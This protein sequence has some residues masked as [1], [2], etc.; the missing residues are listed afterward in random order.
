MKRFVCIV[1]LVISIISLY[2][3][4]GVDNQAYL[5]IHIRA[6]SNSEDDQN[7]KY[8]VKDIVVTYLSPMLNNVNGIDEA[9]NVIN[10]QHDR[11]VA[12]INNY[13]KDC[14]F[15]YGCSVEI[16]N[17]FFPTRTYG[18]LTLQANYYD[19]I[20]IGL[21]DA[22][23]NNWWCVVYPPLCFTGNNVVYKSKILELIK[24]YL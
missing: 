22:S 23:G 19:A 18:N 3:C 8:G 6:N 17:E 5:R 20:I 13:L 16:N 7:V 21:G 15:N 1:M 2:A 9:K 14:G 11:L 12:L 10:E 4:A 24:K